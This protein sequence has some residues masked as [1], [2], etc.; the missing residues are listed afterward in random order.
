VFTHLLTN[1][2]ET[3]MTKLNPKL[4]FFW[5]NHGILREFDQSEFVGD[6]KIYEQK[7]FAKYGYVYYPY[8]C[9]EEGV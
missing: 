8:S 3:G 9:L 2:P 4:D 5:R 1:I 6:T 7:G